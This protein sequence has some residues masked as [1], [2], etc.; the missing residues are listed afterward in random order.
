MADYFGGESA[1]AA[2]PNNQHDA[3]PALAPAAAPAQAQAQAA[4]DDIDMIE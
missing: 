1:Q 2:E 4:T 3:P